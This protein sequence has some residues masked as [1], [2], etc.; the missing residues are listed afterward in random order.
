MDD[1]DFS[2]LPRTNSHTVV[3]PTYR[4]HI[5]RIELYKTYQALCITFCPLS[6]FLVMLISASVGAIDEGL[7]YNP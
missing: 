2:S 6:T 5:I 4:E 7:A 3:V 1:G